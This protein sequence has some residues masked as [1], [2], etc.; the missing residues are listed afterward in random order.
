MKRLFAKHVIAK[1]IDARQ[2]FPAWVKRAIENDAQL[3]SFA[4]QQAQLMD[5]LRA[6][7]GDWADAVYASHAVTG[8]S[9][10]KVAASEQTIVR[11]VPMISSTPVSH[12]TRWQRS[13]PAIV[14]VVS[15]CVLAV[16]AWKVWPVDRVA[17]VETPSDS[18][19]PESVAFELDDVRNAV[20]RSR[21]TFLKLSN[22]SR[23]LAELIPEERPKFGKLTREYVQQ[24]GSIY[25]RSLVMLNSS[26]RP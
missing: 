2:D 3:A 17:K 19:A 1:S 16:V 6:D 24:A 23:Q 4:K 14:T 8:E 5:A 26:A 25:G 10:A 21:E 11:R 15:C 18:V 20:A 9:A 13:L 22:D 7:A 12:R